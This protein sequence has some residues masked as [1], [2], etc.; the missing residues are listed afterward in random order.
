MRIAIAGATGLVGRPLAAA[1][2]AAGH[3]VV[4]IA[5]S[6][7]VD[8]VTGEGLGLTAVEAV[9]D[10]TQSPTL[11]REEAT[12]FF[13]AVASTLGTA[14][15]AA[16]VRRTVLLSINGIDASS[17][18][19]PYHAAKLAHEAATRSHAPGVHVLRA[20]Q[21]HEFAGQMLARMRDGERAEIPDLPLQPVDLEAVVAQLL[22]LATGDDER[23]QVDLVGPRRERLAA[24]AARLDPSVQVLPVPA[25]E[26]IEAGALLGGPGATVAGR[27]FDEWLADGGATVPLEHRRFARPAHDARHR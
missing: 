27:S 6:C 16:G 23:D 26:V 19:N 3:E 7:G 14:A 11:G 17:A 24:M 2:R 20:A 12:A 18:A 10:V 22:A 4:E 8:L 9:V 5:R 21:F 15:R 25:P 13:E 1:A